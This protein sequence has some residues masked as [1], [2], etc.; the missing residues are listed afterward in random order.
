M[1]RRCIGLGLAFAF[2]CAGANATAEPTTPPAPSQPDAPATSDAARSDATIIEPA[3]REPATSEPA[4]SDIRPVEPVAAGPSPDP[5]TRA[6]EHF[7]RAMRAFE[8]GEHALALR[9]FAAADALM[10]M[11][12]VRFNIARCREALGD[13]QGARAELLVLLGRPDIPAAMRVRVREEI[14]ALDRKLG[15]S[16]VPPP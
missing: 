14:L 7:V 5:T 8:A 9:E 3:T 13:L 4:T 10:P 16:S 12:A 11:P 1:L 2:G 6:K 15:I